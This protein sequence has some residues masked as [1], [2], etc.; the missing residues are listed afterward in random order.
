[1]SHEIDGKVQFKYLHIIVL[2]FTRSCCTLPF[3]CCILPAYC[4]YSYCTLYSYSTLS[5]HPD[6]LL[7][8]SAC[9]LYCCFSIEEVTVL[10]SELI[11]QGKRRVWLSPLPWICLQGCTISSKNKV[12]CGRDMNLVWV[13]CVTIKS[14]SHQD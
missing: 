14:V 6:L 13:W 4:L 7:I 1:V 3:L 2:L 9:C 10:L 12:W 8:F 11:S 5:V